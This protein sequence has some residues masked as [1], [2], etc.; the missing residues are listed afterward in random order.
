MSLKLRIFGV[1]VTIHPFFLVMVLLLWMI[2][3]GDGESVGGRH[4][5]A[6]LLIWLLVGLQGVL[7]HELGHA[8]VG[9]RFGLLP[10]VELVGFGGL[11]RWE[12]GR[13]LRPAQ[14]LLVSIAGP[15]VGIALGLPAVF[16]WAAMDFDS[17]SL[18]GYGLGV[19]VLVNLVWAVFNMLP[20]LPLDGGNATAAL[21]Q[22]IDEE[23]GRIRACYVSFVSVGLFGFLAVSMGQTFLAFF[24]ALFAFN[25]WQIL[26]FERSRLAPKPTSSLLK[27]GFAA[28]EEGQGYEVIR[29]AEL[30]VTQAD[31]TDQLDEALH[32]LAWGHFLTDDPAAARTALDSMSGER[33]P[34]PALEGAIE[35]DLGHPERAIPLLESALPDAA[36][37]VTPRLARAKTA[38]T[39]T[40]SRL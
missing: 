33:S 6:G 19:F 3:E 17:E 16:V 5:G 24:L 35:L 1:P 25:T 10:Y 15:S 38:K 13:P 20:I 26:Q 11:T 37:F 2:Y 9:R 34:D 28:L 23:R 31:S 7:M 12:G 32:L 29:L 18:L 22:L 21:L 27:L 36:P 39:G 8:L 40:G 4:G 30:L 14:S